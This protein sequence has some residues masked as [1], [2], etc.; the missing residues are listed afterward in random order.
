MGDNAKTRRI[1]EIF[2]QS[3]DACE[4]EMRALFEAGGGAAPGAAL[5]LHLRNFASFNSTFGFA[6]GEALLRM[7]AAFLVELTDEKIFRQGSGV[8]FILLLEGALLDGAGELASKIA[9]RF[10]EPWQIDG[11]DCICAVSVGVVRYPDYAENCGDL[12]HNLDVA[13][14]QSTKDGH[15]QVTLFDPKLQDRF[16]RNAVIMRLL[17][18]AVETDQ[19]D[20]SYRPIWS[21]QDNRYTR[22][23]CYPRLLTVE[24][25]PVRPSEFFP[26][27]EESGVVCF[28]NM[29]VVR[30]ACETIRILSDEDIEFESLSVK[31]SP[32]LLI[33]RSFVTDIA[34]LLERH[35]IPFGKLALQIMDDPM[36]AHRI[37]PVMK[38]LASLGVEIVLGSADY[39]LGSLHDIIALPINAVKLGRLS[40]WQIEG[41]PR[42]GAVIDGLV[43]ICANLGIKLIASGV[44]TQYQSSLLSRYRCPYRQG[45]YYSLALGLA[46]TKDLLRTRRQ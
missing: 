4:Q 27:A 19:I 5:K 14:A 39:G 34:Q 30:R 12:L 45:P 43:Q 10:E 26:L 32:V 33:Q 23:E 29:H 17:T 3:R 35:R 20:I 40:V 36:S 46:E 25:G 28:V 16:Y 13:V 8:S 7:V 44:E 37:R 21:M 38:K 9:A 22:I 18:T 15:N 24:F 6:K 11:V 31:I 42:S 41:N 1:E 2:G